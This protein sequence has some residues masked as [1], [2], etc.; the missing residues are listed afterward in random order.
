MTSSN[1]SVRT[2]AFTLPS[3]STEYAFFPGAW[4]DLSSTNIW[5]ATGEVTAIICD[6]EIL[7]GSGFV[8]DVH[9]YYDTTYFRTIRGGTN[10]VVGAC[11]VTGPGTLYSGPALATPAATTS[12]SEGGY[13]VYATAKPAAFVTASSYLLCPES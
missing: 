11:T 12:T 9:D 10:S 3:G 1:E 5:L 7:T 6:S 8:L 4:R 2:A 13:E